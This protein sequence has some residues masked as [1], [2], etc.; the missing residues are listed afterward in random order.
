MYNQTLTLLP[1]DVV[2]ELRD[3]AKDIKVLLPK[4]QNSPSTNLLGE[5]IAE[6]DAKKLLGRKT[7]WFFNKRKSRELQGKKKGNKWWYRVSD[8]KNF[9]EN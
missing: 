4:L 2:E 5:W 6:E 7:T 8:I 9:I 3:L 1:L